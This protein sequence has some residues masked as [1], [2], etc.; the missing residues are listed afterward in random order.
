MRGPLEILSYVL[1]LA[2]ECHNAGGTL[3]ALLSVPDNGAH[4]E[5]PVE[6]ARELFILLADLSLGAYSFSQR[7]TIG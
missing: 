4:Q 3:L 6:E 7:L 2:S 1:K 5:S